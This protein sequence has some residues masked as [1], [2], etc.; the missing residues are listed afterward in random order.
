V[1][2]GGVPTQTIFR[3]VQVEGSPERVAK[4]YEL[5]L[6]AVRDAVSFEKQLA[7]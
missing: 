1:S 5:P 7:A 4:L 3:A 2:D 6:G